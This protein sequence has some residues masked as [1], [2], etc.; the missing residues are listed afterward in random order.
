MKRIVGALAVVAI[1]GVVS[2]C[3]ALVL[4]PGCGADQGDSA[5]G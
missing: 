3:A 1:G 2:G 5:C 4:A